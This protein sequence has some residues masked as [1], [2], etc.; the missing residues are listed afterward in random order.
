MSLTK[1]GIIKQNTKTK[2]KNRN[3][4]SSRSFCDGIRDESVLNLNFILIDCVGQTQHT[5]L[6]DLK[7][8]LNCW[9]INTLSLIIV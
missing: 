4:N 2:Y 9:K 5:R 6:N 3:W 7:L 8:D 1:L